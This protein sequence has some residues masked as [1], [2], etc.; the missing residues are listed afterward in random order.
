MNIRLHG[1]EKKIIEV[2]ISHRDDIVVDDVK[3]RYTCKYVF[4]FS[5]MIMPFGIILTKIISIVLDRIKKQFSVLRLVF[6]KILARWRSFKPDRL[7]QSEN[8][9]YLSF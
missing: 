8:D 2:R 3:L 6:K 4:T 9:P 7:S 1:I 5:S